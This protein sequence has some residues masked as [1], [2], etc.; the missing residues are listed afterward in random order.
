MSTSSDEEVTKEEFIAFL[1]R[2][3][4]KTSEE[5]AEIYMFLFLTFVEADV[6]CSAAVDLE[7]FDAMIEIAAA[8]PRRHGLAPT[9]ESM[10]PTKEARIKARKEAF[11][12]M[13]VN[14]NGN[15]SLDEWISYAFEHIFAKV[16]AL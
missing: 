3:L 5:Y 13:D 1:K 14:K 2:A 12:K 4:D 9:S 7:E 16:K 11:E 6:D 15:I 10:Y 8:V